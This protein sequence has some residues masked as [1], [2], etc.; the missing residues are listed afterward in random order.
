MDSSPDTE[1]RMC[2]LSEQRVVVLAEGC[3]ALVSW[4]IYGYG[5]SNSENPELNESGGVSSTSNE[6]LWVWNQML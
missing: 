2:S 6:P 5:W 1:I 3:W 4:D